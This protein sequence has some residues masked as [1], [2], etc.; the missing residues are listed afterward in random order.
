[1]DGQSDNAAATDMAGAAHYRISDARPARKSPDFRA[2]DGGGGN[3]TR[4]RSR[5][6]LNV[7]RCSS[8]FGLARAAGG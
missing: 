8:P 2:M 5:T 4:V 1:M 6:G 3:R 7:Y